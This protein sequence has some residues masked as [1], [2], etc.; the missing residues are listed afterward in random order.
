MQKKILIAEDDLIL[1]S[2][3][4]E[5][6]SV[7]AGFDCTVVKNGREA[8]RLVKRDMYDLLV[9]DQEMPWVDGEE[10]YSRVRKIESYES[11]PIF[12]TTE[13]P[14]TVAPDIQVDDYV[15]VIKK[16][17]ALQ[18][19]LDLMSEVY[20]SA[21]ESHHQKSEDRE[22][23][24]DVQ[25][26]D[27]YLKVGESVLRSLSGMEQIRLDNPA[28]H[29]PLEPLGWEANEVLKFE[30]DFV[31]GAFALMMRKDAFLWLSS[32]LSGTTS[33][34]MEKVVPTFPSILKKI[35]KQV[36]AQLNFPLR[37]SAHRVL[38]SEI[39]LGEGL[40]VRDERRLPIIVCPVRAPFGELALVMCAKSFSS[41]DREKP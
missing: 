20:S 25:L 8:T 33:L 6:F 35:Q 31:A 13:R 4:S 7:D 38:S 19:M 34:Q 9:I 5:F 18:E 15:W 2:R 36:W 23:L 41:P 10:L 29:P 17:F 1:G 32:V 26:L 28:V 40:A 22:Q 21:R 16:P 27:A 12:F 37:E 14:D 3:Y 39:R 30:N 24:V 11:V